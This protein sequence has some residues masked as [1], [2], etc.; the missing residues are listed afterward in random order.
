MI[1]L[2]ESWRHDFAGGVMENGRPAYN[3]NIIIY[4][5]Q[6]KHEI[7]REHKNEKYIIYPAW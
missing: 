1:K 7:M 6:L 2:A 5:I 4:L 3:E